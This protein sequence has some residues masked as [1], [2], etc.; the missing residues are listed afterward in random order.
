MVPDRLVLVEPPKARALNRLRELRD[1]QFPRVNP[2]K[3]VKA[4]RPY[5]PR[6][7]VLLGARDQ[8]A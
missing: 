1:P 5:R 6:G 2:P 3:P 4:L 7:S 8:L